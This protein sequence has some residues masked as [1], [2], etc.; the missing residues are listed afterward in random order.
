MIVLV[1]LP[2]FRICCKVHQ[3]TSISIKI[4]HFKVFDTK[5][6]YGHVISQTI[7]VMNLFIHLSKFVRS[8]QQ[9]MEQD[10]SSTLYDSDTTASDVD[11]AEL[12]H[13]HPSTPPN[14]LGAPISPPPSK[15]RKL[16]SIPIT[17]SELPKP[18]PDKS[19][20]LAAVESGEAHVKD[21]LEYFSRQLSRCI[22]EPMSGLLGVEAWK[23][24]YKR[25]C[26]SQGRHFVVHQHDH[27][28]AGM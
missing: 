5:D 27:P 12:I 16:S 15:R 23:D 9:A 20:S 25:N 7:K 18:E 3:I 28:V 24:L 4:E 11:F 8:V 26:H 14:S 10:L 1:F 13:N 21:H 2:A 17:T 19:S 22:R 6:L